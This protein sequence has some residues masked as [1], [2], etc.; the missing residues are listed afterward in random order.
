MDGENKPLT[1]AEFT[2]EKKIKDDTAEGG[3]RWKA[4]QVVK[5]DE[6]TAFTFSGLD[7]GDYRLTETATPAGYNTIDPIEFTITAEH[8]VL[9]DNPALTSLNG[10][11][12]TGEI[13]FTSSIPDGSLS[14]DIVNQ[15]GAT[16][17][18]TGGMGTTLFYIVGS[19]LVIGAGV[20]LITKRRMGASH[21]NH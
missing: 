7:D 8:D 4:V 16:L 15:S 5:N 2:L 11:A 13:T 20:L 9:S 17:P 6:G 10:N 12:A 19:A 3:F 1:G 18:E 14:A 21:H